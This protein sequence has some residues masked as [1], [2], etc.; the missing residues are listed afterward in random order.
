MSDNVGV[1]IFVIT[2]IGDGAIVMGVGIVHL[3]SSGCEALAIQ[4][5]GPIER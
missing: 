5:S 2:A 3:Q 1:F 4:Q